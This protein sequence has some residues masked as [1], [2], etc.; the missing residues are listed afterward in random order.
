[1]A[2]EFKIKKNTEVPTFV[3]SGRAMPFE[4]DQMKV[5][6]SFIVPKEFW[7]T[8][9]GVPAAKNTSADAKDRIRRS[10]YNW[11]GEVPER[12]NVTVGFNT[13]D[14]DG[15]P[16]KIAANYA[17]VECFMI[18]ATGQGGGERAPKKAKKKK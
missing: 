13:L 9:R 10:F 7:P 2:F 6:D 11:Q 18:H 16:T 12:Q 15:K 8:E 17:A 14:K 4:W 3:T 1:M 5:T